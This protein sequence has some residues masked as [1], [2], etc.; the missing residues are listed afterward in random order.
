MDIFGNARAFVTRCNPPAILGAYNL[1]Q[2]IPQ[3]V[4][5]QYCEFSHMHWFICKIYIEPYMAFLDCKCTRTNGT[6]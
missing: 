2:S 5:P 6:E 3:D 4:I 1:R